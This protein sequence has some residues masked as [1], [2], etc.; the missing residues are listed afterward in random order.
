[1]AGPA[2]VIVAGAV[3]AWLAI[4]G[5]DGLVEDDYYKQGLAV[6]QRKQRDAEAGAR[7]LVVFIRLGGDGRR[8]EMEYHSAAQLPK[9]PA[10][11]L[12]LAHPTRAGQDID[13]ALALGSDGVYRGELE[14][15]PAG[16]WYV[17]VDDSTLSWRL[18]GEW[19]V[20]AGSGIRLQARTADST[21][22][23]Q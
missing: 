14:R 11:G 5:M 18:L 22:G 13:V 20:V 23:G 17:S 15:T 6:N 19:T 10:V 2:A 9:P 1:M 7:G 16:R 3:T 12:H 8:L 21:T 4:S